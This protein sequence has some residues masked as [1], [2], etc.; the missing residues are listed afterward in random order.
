MFGLAVRVGVG[1]PGLWGFGALGGGC[2]GFIGA[3]GNTPQAI[4]PAIS[5]VLKVGCLPWGNPGSRPLEYTVLRNA[6]TASQ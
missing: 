2:S 6:G 4:F 1:C 3:A 5:G